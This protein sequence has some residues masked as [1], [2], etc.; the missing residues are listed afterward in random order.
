[1][2]LL[3]MTDE[4]NLGNLRIENWQGKQ[5]YLKKTRGLS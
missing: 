4:R 2:H 5:E 3:L 1:M